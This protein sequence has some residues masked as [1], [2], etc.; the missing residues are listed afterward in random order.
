M[1]NY[2]YLYLNGDIIRTNHTT[3]SYH[4]YKFFEYKIIKNK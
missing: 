3:S 4:S 2:Y 1:H